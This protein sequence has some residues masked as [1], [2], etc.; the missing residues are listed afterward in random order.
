M[1][2][3]A[4]VKPAATTPAV[5]TEQPSQDDGIW[6]FLQ[7]RISSCAG[8]DWWQNDFLHDRLLFGGWQRSRQH[9]SLRLDA[10]IKI[11]KKNEDIRVANYWMILRLIYAK[12]KAQYRTLDF[13]LKTP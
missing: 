4:I 8:S 12:L 13:E 2:I 5:A 3:A 7:H 1:Y 6:H 9:A 10:V 11:I